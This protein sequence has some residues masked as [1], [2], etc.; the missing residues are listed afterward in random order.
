MPTPDPSFPRRASLSRVVPARPQFRMRLLTLAVLSACA[1]L[2][3]AAQ[4]QA[5]APANPLPTGGVVS[6]PATASI[7]NSAPNLMQINQT[8]AKTTIHWNSFDIG[9][10]YTVRFNQPSSS[11]E[12]MN[13]IGGAN[14]SVIQGTL[15]ANGKV[16]LVN[17]N[18]ILFD[19]TAQVNVNT[20]IASSLD[21]S[22]STFD[23]GITSNLVGKTDPTMVAT[24]VLNTAGQVINYGTIRSVKVD[25]STGQVA[26]DP[27]TGKPVEEGGAIMLFAPQ[28]ENHGLITANNGQVILAA[29]GT[30]YL[31]LYNDPTVANSNPNDFSMRGFLVKVTAAPEGSLNLSQLI[32]AQKLNSAANLGGEIHTDRGNTTLTGLVVNQSGLVSANTATTVNGSIWLKAENYDASSRQTTYGTLTTSK[33][34]V[35]QVIPEDDGTTLAESDPYADNSLYNNGSFPHYQGVIKLLG[36]TV[37]HDGQAVAPG[38]RIVVGKEYVNNDNAS[39]PAQT[40]RVYLGADSVLSTAGLWVDLPYS[41]NYLTFKLGSL[42]LAN[43][44][45]QKGGFLINQTVT[46]DLRKGTP[47]LFDIA[48]KLAAVPRSVREKATAGGTITVNTGEFISS[49][50]SKVDVSGGGYR[51]GDGM[52]I[53]TYLTSRGRL[54]D[55]ATAPVNLQYDGVVTRTTPAKGYVQGKSAGLL[56]ID[57]Q[58]MI[59][60]GHFAAGVT[61]GPYQRAPGAMPTAG[62]LVLGTQSILSGSTLDFSTVG[63]A[64]TANSLDTEQAAYA[65]QNVTFGTGATTRQQLAEAM[66]GLD[67]DPVNAAFPVALRDKVLLPT[68]LF[69]GTAYRTAQASATQGFGTLA[70]R[71]NDSIVVPQDVALDLGAGGSLLW[72][73]PQI[74]VAGTVRAAGGSLAFNRHYESVL[75]GNTHLGAHGVLSVAGNW[76]NDASSAQGALSV[77]DVIDGGSVTIAGYGTL[78]AG[79]LIDASGGA[80][81]GS[82]GKLSYGNG[83]SIALPTTLLDGVTLW[84]Y[85]GKQGGSLTLGMDAIDVGGH[86]AAALSGDFFTRGGF[87]QYTLAGISQVNFREDVHPVAAQRV[88]NASAQLAPSGTAFAD[89]SSVLSGMP[90]YLR[91]AASLTATTDASTSTTHQLGAFETGITVAPGVSLRTDPLGTI[92]LLSKSRLDVEGALIAPGGQINLSLDSGKNFYYDTASGRFNAL[93]IGGQAVVSTAGV[94]LPD[95][96]PHGLTTGQVLPGGTVSITASKN[97]LDIAQG[98]LIDV[99]GTRHVVDLP[100]SSGRS[101]YLHANVASEGG[102]IAIKATENAYLDGTFQ[103]RGGDDSVAGGSFALDLPYNG[104]F[105]S[106]SVYGDLL[107]DPLVQNDPNAA[108]ALAFWDAG[109]RQLRHTIVVSQTASPLLRDG[110]PDDASLLS[111]LMDAQGNFVADLRANISADQLVNGVAQGGVRVGGGF[112]NVLLKSDN[113]IQFTAGVDNFA[114]RAALRLDAPELLAQG[115]GTTRIGSG[116]QAGAAWQT[117]QLAWVNTPDAFRMSTNLPQSLIEQYPLLYSVDAATGNMIPFPDPRTQYVPVETYAGSGDLDLT[118]GQ[119]SLAGNVTANGMANLNLT[120]RGDIRFEGFPLGY[121][122]QTS[123]SDPNPLIASLQALSGRLSADANI[124]L[125]ANQVYP[126]TA[127]DYTVAS[128]Q[129]SIAQMKQDAS[130]LGGTVTALVSRNVLGDG[131]ISVK[132]NEGA[133]LAPVLSAGGTLTLQADHIDQAGVI[134]APLGKINLEGGQSLSLENGSVTSVSALWQHDGVETALVIPYG[135]TQSVGQSLWYASTQTETAPDKQISASAGTVTVASGATLDIRGG[136]DFAAM[137]FV[138]GI[139][140]T[141]DVLAAPGTYAIVPGVAF[142]TSDSY[143]DS[144]APVSV[145][146]AS[147]YD[148]VHLGAG[149][150]LPEGDYALLPA[151]YALL[152]GAYLVKTQT[153]TGSANLSPGYAATQPDGSVVVAGQLGYAGT[154]IRQSTWSGFSVQSGADALTG[155]HAQAQYLLTGSAFFADQAARNNT[156]ATGMPQDGGRL[157]V[158]ATTSLAFEGNLLAQAA[159]DTATGKVGAIGQVDIYGSKFAIVDPAA[160]A[161]AGYTRLQS[162]DLSRLGASLLIGG[163]RTDTANGQSLDVVASDVIVDLDG[164]TLSLPELWLAATDN[165]TVSGDSTL[166]AS[167]N[168]VGRAGTLTVDTN[169]DGTQYGALLGLSGGELAPVAR[170]GTLNA[171]PSHGNL[172]I[173]AGAKLS[174]QGGSIVVDSTGTPQMDGVMDSDSLAIGARQI[175]L[176]D[177]PQGSPALALGNAQLAALGSARNFVLRSYSSIDLYGNVSLGQAGAGS[178]TFDSAGLVGHDVNGTSAPVAL[179]AGTITLENLSGTTLAANAPGTG[180]LTLNADKLV[181]ADSSRNDAGFTVAGFNQVDLSAGEVSLQGA[182]TL[183][184]ASD[185]NLAAG[186]IAAGGRMADQQ[187]QAYDAGQQAW[188]AVRVTQPASVTAFA[189]TPLPGGKLKID[190]SSVDFGGNV[191]L[192]SGRLALAAHGTAASDGVTLENGSRID[193]SAYEK[194]F[195]QG[196]ANLTESASAGRLTLSSEHGSVDAKAGSSIDL[197]GGVAGGDAGM[198]TVSAANGTVALDGTLSASAAPGQRSGSANIDSANLA[199]FSALNAAL[200]SGGFGQSRTLRARAGDVTVAA[201]DTVT[202]KNIQLVADAGAINVKGRLDASGAAGGGQVELDAGQGIHLYGG[203]RIA[204]SG[205]STDTAADAAYS[206]GGKVALYARNGQLDFDSGAVIDVSAAAAGKSSGGEVVFSAPRTANGSGLQA[207]LAGQVKVAGGT[208][209]VPGGL[210]PQAGRVV[211]EGFKAYSGITTTSSAASTSGAVY[212]DYDTFMNAADGIHDAALITLLA[213]GSDVASGNLKVRAG[214]ELVSGGDLMVDAAWDLTN[215]AW[216]RTGINQTAGRLALR[217]AGNLAVNARLG[218]PNESAVPPD[219]G[220]SLQLAAGA[221]TAS[222]DALAVNA[223]TAQGDVTLGSQGK[224]TTSTGDIQIAA[225]RD[226]SAASPVSVVYTTG[227]ALTLPILSATGLKWAAPAAGV[228]FVD[229][230]SIAIRAQRDINGSGSY[231]DVNDWLRRTTGTPGATLTSPLTSARGFAYLPAYWWVDRLGNTAAK[232]RG[233]EGI[234]TLGGGGIDIVA[235]NSVRNVAVASATSRSAA[236]TAS[237]VTVNN[238][239]GIPSENAV[240]GGGN[241]RIDAGGDLLGGQYLVGRG[242]ARLSAGGDIGGSNGIGDSATAPAFWLM[243]WS[244]DPALQGA[245]VEVQAL[246]SVVLGSVANPTVVTVAKN[247]GTSITN[248]TPGYRALPGFFF[249]YSSQDSLAVKSVG[250]DVA[251]LGAESN[252]AVQ[253]ANEVLPPRFSAVALEGD[254]NG[255]THYFDNGAEK[256]LTANLANVDLSF[257]QFPDSNGLFRL[258]AGNSVHDLSLK[259]SDYLPASLTTA[260]DPVL[261][262][263]DYPSSKSYTFNSPL[264]SDAKMVTPST[265]GGYRYAVVADAGSVSNAGFY[266]PQQAV[267][268]AGQDIANVQLDLQNL[269]AGDVSQVA[270]GRDLFYSNVLSN[271]T[272]WGNMPHLQIAGPGSL[273]VGAGRNVNLGAVSTAKFQGDINGAN[274]VTRIDAIGNT[275]NLSLPTA[276]A[277]TL[278]VMSGVDTGSLGEAQVDSLFGV[279]RSVGQLQGLLGEVRGNTMSSDAAIADANAVIQ[280]ANAAIGTLFA[281]PVQAGSSPVYL[282]PLDANGRTAATQIADAYN[283][284]LAAANNAIAALF[285]GGRQHQGDITLY[286]ARISSTTN[287][288]GAGGDISLLAPHGDIKV[289]LPT[290]SSGRNI[291]IYTTAGGAINAYL[292]GDMN[293]NLSKVATFQGGDILLYTSGAGSTLDAG[294]GSRSARTSSPPRLVAELKAD[295]TPTGKLLL[296]PPLDVSGSGIRT[297]SYDPDGFGPLQ[298]PDPGKVYLLAP[299]GTID[300]GEAGV[301]SASG[302]VVAAQVVKNADNFSASGSSVGVPAVSSGAPA[303]PVSSDAAASASKAMDAVS[304]AG[305]ALAKN[306]TD[307]KS[308]RPAFITVEVLGFG[309]DAAGCGK[310]D[311]TCRKQKSGG[312]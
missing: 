30:V 35:T 253:K 34:S 192:Q 264:V 70:V 308:F 245:G 289:G 246:G 310:D 261:A 242:T 40:G 215:A 298:Q 146:A 156:V 79:S 83:G 160:A 222:A 240:Y 257:Y 218:L 4:N 140:G 174:A 12:A 123:L 124:T 107:L 129:V 290:A 106:T 97:D 250:G 101:A 234:A 206:D 171:D 203:G 150:G 237:L 148:M 185:L 137:E 161:P 282:T 31:Q 296:L 273:V 183:S 25:G 71:A 182:G 144:L 279:L 169:A 110:S 212:S 68:D 62:K 204:A 15:S 74:E 24:M 223:S 13:Y 78:D 48:D 9:Q 6:D 213:G 258:L 162:D 80:M 217:A 92:S 58:Q 109:V 41:D 167:G 29:G 46:V 208:V 303:A 51:Y 14:P 262:L 297:V 205:T 130:Q 219:S 134:K 11:A 96:G 18:G 269:G 111:N 190:G 151:Y 155:T 65:L 195:A 173:A 291:G 131:L 102:R 143:L 98:A 112:D 120:S 305:S 133:T 75:Y 231:A 105:P 10:G 189:D 152:P 184:V 200:E 225:G 292:S 238:R 202:A 178:F 113:R 265:L 188:H 73:A 230:G 117:A 309:N 193:L 285:Q 119:I 287:P 187:I 311:E 43:A 22:Q 116:S 301:S 16:Y 57:A 36:E 91:T 132:G 7:V 136:G 37:V 210:A 276:D 139:G 3:L 175:A 263:S 56:A 42:D 260:S 21:I 81:L 201:T 53:T 266:F 153:G 125:Q 147:A 67:A 135:A 60:G 170:V 100:P 104:T 274:D 88:A 227:R 172:T 280:S 23:N 66:S 154:G 142:R 191:V 241:V 307:L 69:G 267:V 82:T 49:A 99:S 300:A 52:A 194:T 158:G 256:S 59:L 89:I 232:T 141:K 270:A 275:G 216:L 17:S 186:R 94:F 295:G 180:T 44:P 45:L 38:G 277:A 64:T 281:G 304:Q 103:G 115:G 126:A 252:P 244:D 226:F 32:A 165:L 118:A 8:A 299:T 86:S 312:T 249:S 233:I 247:A 198:L 61:T 176:G 128:E 272:Q 93:H 306:D 248:T 288:G 55:I 278:I 229:G 286:N 54:Y 159:V 149:S 209:S 138:P 39:R 239:N 166:A 84:G 236:T 114:P 179:S 1:S 284:A 220:W 72:L 228:N 127:V 224:V 27:A 28:V 293:V 177:V 26:T 211:L 243:G 33:D 271:G 121:L 254:V 157:S 164:G 87:T 235:G 90:D 255:G 2:S 259:Q 181:L 294:R 47:R 5:A 251:L 221:D 268:T 85:G 108:A 63:D 302:L 50:G 207:A 196:T 20:L 76:I 19:G 122:A 163:K 283:G 77:P 199:N 197:R 214:V 168:V 95:A 145:K